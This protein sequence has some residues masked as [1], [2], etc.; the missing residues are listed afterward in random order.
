MKEPSQKLRSPARRADRQG[1]PD[2]RARQSRNTWAALQPHG[3]N[4]FDAIEV[5]AL[6]TR[7]SLRSL[8]T[9]LGRNGRSEALNLCSEIQTVDEST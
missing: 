3:A 7:S 6:P 8:P 2:R 5:A 9:I 4:N 1:R